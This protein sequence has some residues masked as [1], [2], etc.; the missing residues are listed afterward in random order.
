MAIDWDLV[1]FKGNKRFLSNMYRCDI[2]F[3][4]NFGFSHF[5]PDFKLYKSSE[6]LY[7]ALKSQN[8]EYQEIIR[9]LNNP[10]DTKKMADK[11]IGSKYK[12]RK[13][14]DVLK[15]DVMKIALNLKFSQ[16]PHLFE[17]LQQICGHIEEKNSWE[18]RF[19]GTYKGEG[20]NKLG[21]LLMQ[22]R[23]KKQL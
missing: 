20:L 9:N 16:N 10:K 12:L 8:L 13:N 23:D 21:I 15:I 6:H 19:W 3:D 11:L 14:W 17:K 4:N 18:D 2:V 7:Q 22:I 5:E 1:E